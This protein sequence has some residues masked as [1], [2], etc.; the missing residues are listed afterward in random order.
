MGAR[1]MTTSIF[2]RIHKTSFLNLVFFFLPKGAATACAC[3]ACAGA[4][5]A[6][7]HPGTAPAGAALPPPSVGNVSQPPRVGNA[8]IFVVTVLYENFFQSSEPRPA[9]EAPPNESPPTP[10]K[11]S[12]LYTPDSTLGDWKNGSAP[13][14]LATFGFSYRRSLFRSSF[15]DHTAISLRRAERF[16][17]SGLKCAMVAGVKYA[18]T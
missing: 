5:F 3:A 10:A 8:P 13:F 12:A 15:L 18:F 2:C 7:P 6:A 17:T 16:A 1:A 4:A 11:S 9:P 14:T